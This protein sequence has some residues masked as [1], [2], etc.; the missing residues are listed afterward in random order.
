MNSNTIL[1]SDV[2]D[3]LFE[4]RNKKYGAYTLR[5]FYPNRVKTSLFI[6]FGM[7]AIFSAFTLLPEKKTIS[8]YPYISDSSIIVKTYEERKELEKPKQKQTDVSVRP[9]QKFL[10]RIEIVKNDKKTDSLH[11][12]TD[13]TI[14]STTVIVATPPS[15]GDLFP[16]AEPGGG[17]ATPS[18]PTV[19]LDITY[20]DPDVPPTYPGGN[21]ELIRFLE[22]NL[23]S[24]EDIGEAVQVKIKFVVDNDG[25]LESFDIVH[26]GGEAFNKEV[27][28]VLKK[29]PQ[30]NPGKKGGRNVKA[31][32]YLPVKF[33]PNE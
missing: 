15:T 16:P 28:R 7:A 18:E 31:Y 3:I 20:E 21:K 13:L 17:D 5:K 1:S 10:D 12:I 24:P 32:C 19:D 6:M 14:S 26:D 11:D 29:M 27:I 9:S 33:Q 4:N 8:A 2:L 25:N 22:R 30:W 23:L